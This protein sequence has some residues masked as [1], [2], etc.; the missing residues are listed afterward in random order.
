VDVL[1]RALSL[2]MIV[3]SLEGYVIIVLLGQNQGTINAARL[4]TE[5]RGAD[6]QA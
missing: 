2:R 3:F 6:R 4:Q 1:F 5:D